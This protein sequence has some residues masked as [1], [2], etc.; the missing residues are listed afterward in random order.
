MVKEFFKVKFNTNETLF[1]LMMNYVAIQLTK[2]CIVFWENP[3]DSNTVGIINPST[4]SG[5]LPSIANQKFLI[6]I[7]ENHGIRRSY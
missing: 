7:K 6:N 5:W 3:K 1:T 2:F 4:H